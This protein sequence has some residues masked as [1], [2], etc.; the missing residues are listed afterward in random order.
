[1]FAAIRIRAPRLCISFRTG[2]APVCPSALPFKE[3]PKG[4]HRVCRMSNKRSMAMRKAPGRTV[5]K[6][7]G[8]AE[9]PRSQVK[10]CSD[11][12][13]HRVQFCPHRNRHLS[14]C[15]SGLYRLVFRMVLHITRVASHPPVL[16]VHTWAQKYTPPPPPC[17][18]QSKS[19]NR[20]TGGEVRGV[21]PP[22]GVSP[23]QK[24]N[25]KDN[26]VWIILLYQ[27]PSLGCFLKDYSPL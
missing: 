21:Y 18:L 9:P 19:G 7:P 20:K 16:A 5:A 13:G 15:G 6:I 27:A 8:H 1:M 2:F 25:L 17:F 24:W 23:K 12:T 4:S 22:Q 10:G 3:H 11:F 14:L 26:P